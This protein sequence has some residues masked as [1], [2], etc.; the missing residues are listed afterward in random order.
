MAPYKPPAPDVARAL[1]KLPLLV[2]PQVVL[3]PRLRV[4]VVVREPRQLQLVTDVVG[5]HRALG[6]VQPAEATA[7]RAEARLCDVAAVGTVVEATPLPGGR[8]QVA[9]IG[10]GRVKLSEL[11]DA[12]PCPYPRA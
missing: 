6:I 12:G 11:H 8:G 10:R 2:D 1:A 5:T 3:F 4:Q 9:V 7:G